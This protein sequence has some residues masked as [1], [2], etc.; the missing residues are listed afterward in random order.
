MLTVDEALQLILE[1]VVPAPVSS[2]PLSDALGA[3]LAEE[4]ISSVD[5]PPFD[6]SMMDGFAVRSADCPKGEKTLSIIGEVMAGS[7]S[8]K[9]LQPGTAIRIMTG[10]P[11]P[12]GADAVVPV[13]LTE[14]AEDSA[15]VT[16]RM[17]GSLSTEWNVIRR[18]SLMAKGE[19]ILQPGRPLT[20]QQLALLG[21]I[22]KS[23]VAVRKVPTVAVLATG[24]ELVEIDETPGPGQ[25][26][27]TNALMLAAQVQEAGARPRVLGIARDDRE[28]LAAKIREG[29]QADVLCLSGGVSA[30]VLDLVPSELAK[31]DVRQVFHKIRMK[32]GKP[33]WFGI[34]DGAGERPPC[35]VFGLP[36]NPVSSMVC[37]ELF[38]RSALRRLQGM[39]VAGPGLV[40]ARLASDFSHRSDR[41]TWFPCRLSRQ[42]ECLLATPMNWK[43]SSDLR[44]TALANASLAIPEGEH[45]FEAGTV[46][47]VLPWGRTMGQIDSPATTGT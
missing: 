24:D 36:G 10:A 41:P 22:G 12:D 44:A 31:A 42:Q 23:T 34:R 46:L 1:T 15:S 13:E 9:P 27:N 11:I 45:Q 2:L 33:L 40:Q 25:I 20:A 30:G 5:S 4:V 32:P 29:L 39:T 21:E 8:D 7:V 19:A 3:V 28:D 18:G 35:Y 17:P 6:K 16:L 38:V 37:F 47:E 14:T 26:R 43:G